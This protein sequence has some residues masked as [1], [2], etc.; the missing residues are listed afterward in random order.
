M[1]IVEKGTAISRYTKIDGEKVH[2]HHVTMNKSTSTE[3][4]LDWTFDFTD[5]THDELLLI[6][7]R[8]LVIKSRP[9]FKLLPASE[10]SG[11]DEKVF[12]VREML[13][14]ETRSTLT[15][16]QKV[17]KNITKLDDAAKQRMIDELQKSLD[18]LEIVNRKKTEV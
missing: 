8:D 12:S 10:L 7:S 1:R 6:A 2:K 13:D 14:T 17:M 5:V 11:W 18:I 9:V 4:E 16:E 3:Y 15:P